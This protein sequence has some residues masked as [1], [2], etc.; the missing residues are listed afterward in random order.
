MAQ[1]SLTPAEQANVKALAREHRMDARV[2]QTADGRRHVKWINE[3]PPEAAILIYVA[4]WK[5]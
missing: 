5:T 1:G 3:D 4:T 2:F